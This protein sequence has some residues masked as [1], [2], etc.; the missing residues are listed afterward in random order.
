MP[1]K[2]L[3]VAIIGCGRLGQQYA[4]AYSNYP[5]T[6]L[7]AI[8]EHN[9]ERLKA[10]GNRFGT[11]NLYSNIESMLKDIVPDIAAVVTPTKW[12]KESVIKCSNAGVKGISTDKP[13]A[14]K[15]SDADEMIEVCKANGTIF[16]GGNLAVAHNHVQETA[17]WI[18]EG[19]FGQIIGGVVNCMA[20]DLTG[21]GVQWISALRLLMDSEIDQIIAW[22]KPKSYVFNNSSVM[23]SNGIFTM[24]NGIQVPFFQDNIIDVY[25]EKYRKDKSTLNRTKMG[26]DIWS[27]D[28]LIRWFWEDIDIYKG[29]D[30]LGR[31][32]PYIPKYKDWQWKEFNYLTGSTRSLIN[33]VRT[34]SKLAISGHDLRQAIE[35]AIGIKLSAQ[36][37]NVPIKLPLND[38]SQSL[39]PAQARW[40]GGDLSGNPQTISE[41]ST[42]WKGYYQ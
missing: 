42:N 34:G 23:H 25:K 27:N 6:E 12:M 32:K 13:M 2:K 22:G 10:V 20:D 7:I 19:K 1:L 4:T 40:V 38:R 5:D 14:A 36:M 41:A 30:N 21:G 31:R 15:L 37:G 35:V 39:M 9:S 28:S 11:N 16:A 18:K 3:K 33:A 29:F 8:T 26:L 24:V 17:R